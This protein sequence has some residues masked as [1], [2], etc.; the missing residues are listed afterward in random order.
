VGNK[1]IAQQEQQVSFFK[2]EDGFPLL[3]P[4]QDCLKN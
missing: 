1:A 3:E 4:E 2:I